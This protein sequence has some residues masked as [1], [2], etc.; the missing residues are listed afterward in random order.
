MIRAAVEINARDIIEHAT[1]IAEDSVSTSASLDLRT[2]TVFSAVLPMLVGAS[3]Q[4]QMIVTGSRGTTALSRFLMGSVSSSL[5]RHAHCPVAV[6]HADDDLADAKAPVLVGV[7]GSPAS[8]GAIALAF[9]EASRRGVRL[10]AL[11]AWSD[12]GVFPILGMAPQDYET[13]GAEILA[14]RLAGWQQTYPDVPV[15]RRL[16]CDKPAHWLIEESQHAQLVVLGSRGRGGFLGMTL[17]SVSSALAQSAK[18]PVIV[19]RTA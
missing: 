2:E 4:A 7:D 9:D 1:K 10:V 14:E 3:T 12:F 19:H 16:V 5:L 17:G 6:I 8:E 15:Q 18:A 13:R 11:H